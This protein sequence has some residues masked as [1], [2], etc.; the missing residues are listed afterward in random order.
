MR[1][2][3]SNKDVSPF[4]YKKENAQFISGKDE[5]IFGWITV[6]FIQGV[7]TSRRRQ[8]TWGTLDLGGASTQNTMFYRRKTDQTT[9]LT[10][11]GRSYRLFAKSYL[12]TGL[13]RIHERFLE[14]L[15]DWDDKTED[16]EGNINSPCHHDGFKETFD[17]EDHK[18]GV[19]GVPNSE[20]C[21]ELV[22][23]MLF[24]TKKA[25]NQECPFDDQPKLVG[26]FMAF[27][28][29]YTVIDRIGAIVCE[30]KPVTVEQIGCGAI[31][32]CSKPYNVVKPADEGYTKFSCLWGHYVYELL[33]KGYQMPPQKQIYVKKELKGYSLS[34]TIGALLY[35][36][37][38]L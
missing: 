12:N 38:L 25:P 17:V 32:Y 1:D 21:R 16:D 36:T 29:F 3:L 9:P 6:N 7:L 34:W 14:L 18:V 2:V 10:V 13:A 11:G 27:S 26:K 24:C 28:A 8:A 4:L 37:D 31:K 23:A 22:D 15:V 33:S 20:L 19:V 5:A 30:D 35:K